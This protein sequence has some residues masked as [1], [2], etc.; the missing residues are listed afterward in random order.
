MNLAAESMSD[1][2]AEVDSHWVACKCK[3]FSEDISIS[4]THHPWFPCMLPK[5]D[6]PFIITIPIIMA[7]FLSSCH[8]VVLHYHHSPTLLPLP[9]SII[10]SNTITTIMIP[11]MIPTT[12][13]TTTILMT[14][15]MPITT[16][17]ILMITCTEAGRR[18]RAAAMERRGETA[19]RAMADMICC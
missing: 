2:G 15:R 12:T 3:H 17:T 9:A 11:N 13:T 14:N 6:F 19:R 5:A 7:I 10:N 4:N 1:L 16:T 18:L 8:E